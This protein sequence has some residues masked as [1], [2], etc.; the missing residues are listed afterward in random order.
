MSENDS[1]RRLFQ[2]PV[3]ADATE[4]E[5]QVPSIGSSANTQPVSMQRQYLIETHGTGV[6]TVTSATSGDFPS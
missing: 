1:L 3:L 2:T 4:D 5:V 6:S